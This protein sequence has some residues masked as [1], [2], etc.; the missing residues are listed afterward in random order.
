M[1]KNC[2]K[3]GCLNYQLI[4]YFCQVVSFKFL[5]SHE[6]TNFFLI[7]LSLSFVFT[8]RRVS[9]KDLGKG[10]CEGW[11]YKRKKTGGLLSSKWHKRWFVLKN[12]NL[13]YYKHQEVSFG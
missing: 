6:S 11:L 3:E 12:Y 9:C 2:L 8:D 5:V 1:N 10:D 13:Y 4:S 7:L